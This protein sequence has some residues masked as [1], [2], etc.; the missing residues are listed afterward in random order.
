MHLL[1]PAVLGLAGLCWAVGSVSAQSLAP[2]RAVYELS[3]DEASDRSGIND[4]D[5]RMVYE[6]TGSECEGYTITFRFVM[7]LLT[8][9]LTR[10]SDQQTSTYESAD[11]ET[12]HFV[13]RIFLDNVLDKEVAG[14]ATT[15]GSETVVELEKPRERSV[16]L[17]PTQF[18]TAHLKELVDKAKAGENF[19]QTTLF[20]GSED[21]DKVM[22]TAVTIGRPRPAAADDPERA[23][24][25]PLADDRFWPVTMAYFDGAQARGEQTPDYSISFLLH[26][27]GLTR[28]LSMDYGEFTVAGTLTGLTLFDGEEPACA[29]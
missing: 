15:G 3:L 25:R 28:D 19:Y 8:D 24:M 4:I 13:T 16:A 7:R 14:V 21:A 2:H 27:N 17:A 26:E 29:E 1:R 12:F 5:G 18:P 6:F 9:E 10:L 11:G 23:A 22:M 20:D